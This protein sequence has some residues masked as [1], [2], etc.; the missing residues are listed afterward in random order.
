MPTWTKCGLEREEVGSGVDSCLPRIAD[1]LGNVCPSLFMEKSLH[2]VASIAQL[3]A[4]QTY[5][6]GI[7]DFLKSHSLTTPRFSLDILNWESQPFDYKDSKLATRLT[8]L[9]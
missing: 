5:R 4:P 7:Q 8:L 6:L 9:S 2:E 1:I 3:L